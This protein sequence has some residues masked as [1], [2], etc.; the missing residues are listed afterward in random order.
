MSEKTQGYGI[1]DRFDGGPIETADEELER[2]G[3]EI[4]SL[5]A[6]LAEVEAARAAAESNASKA[7]SAAYKLEGLLDRERKARVKAERERDRLRTENGRLRESIDAAAGRLTRA[8]LVQQ[9]STV[10]GAFVAIV[11]V[12]DYLRAALAEPTEDTP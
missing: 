10:D 3:D 5:R 9:Y 11:R 12:R 4:E 7:G 6:R 1:H 2:L 8:L